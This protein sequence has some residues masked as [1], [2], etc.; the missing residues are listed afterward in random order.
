MYAKFCYAAPL[1]F[2]DIVKKTTAG[3]GGQND[4]HKGEG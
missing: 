4:P 2:W 3:G 1:D